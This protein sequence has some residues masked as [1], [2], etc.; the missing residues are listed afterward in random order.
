MKTKLIEESGTKFKLV[1]RPVI[2]VDNILC[3]AK[4]DVY[5]VGQNAL[6]GYVS[7]LS[8]SGFLQLRSDMLLY[9]A[10]AFLSESISELT[11]NQDRLDYKVTF[12]DRKKQR[13]KKFT[14]EYKEW[15]ARQQA[16]HEVST[17][18]GKKLLSDLG[19]SDPRCGFWIGIG[20]IPVVR[21]AFE[22][23]ILAGWD[24]NLGQVK[25]KFNQLRIYWNHNNPDVEMIFIEAEKK[26]DLLC[27]ECG[28]KREE[29]GRGVGR[30]QC[31][32]CNSYEQHEDD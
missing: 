11:N 13:S 22:K 30:P 20:W 32:L 4:V 10:R 29:S 8:C 2:G 15:A 5:E 3:W 23:A 18:E 14:P 27:E 24:K 6:F 26:C 31:N 12:S 9:K 25:E 7:D 17:A 19:I 21:E 1:F 28:S 16:F